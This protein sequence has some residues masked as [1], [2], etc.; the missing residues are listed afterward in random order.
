MSMFERANALFRYDEESGSLR[1]KE[2]RIAPLKSGNAIV[3]AKAG[4]IAGGK[5]PDG[6]VAVLI[7]GK[8]YLAHRVVWL[9][10][11]GS[12]P[13]KHLDHV[14]GIRCD[15]RIAN[16]RQANDSQNGMNRAAQ[17][18]SK[19]G[20]K[21]VSWSERDR[22]WVA[23]IKAEGKYRSLGYYRTIHEAAAAYANAARRFHQEFARV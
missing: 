3:V 22:R 5:R 13:R 8:S 9:L 21:G 16:L 14:N 4:E 15:N 10:T 2:D 18:N 23:R 19:S 11:H 6:Y 1:W 20:V 7:G 17:A 12:W